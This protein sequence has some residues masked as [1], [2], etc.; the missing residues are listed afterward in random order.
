MRS[1][2][3]DVIEQHGAVL[4]KMP[5][6]A[7][8]VVQA[9]ELVTDALKKGGRVL[10]CGNGGSAA[11]A[12]HLAAEFT[13]RFLFDRRPLDAQALHCDTSALTAVGNDYGFENVFV[14]QVMAHGRP[15]DVLVGLSTSGNSRNVIKAFETAETMDIRTI[16][17]TGAQGRAMSR[18]DIL[19]AV[20]SSHTPRIQEMHIMLGHILCEIVE[21][22]LCG[23]AASG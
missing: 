8:A 1:K 17:L 6:L 2:Y 21:E 18:A 4:A 11:D 19:I 12:Q 7:D 20:P 3:L 23:A 15:G 13:G 22:A 14:R 9:A 5:P 16:G 10:F